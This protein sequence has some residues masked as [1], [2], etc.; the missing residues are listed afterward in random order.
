[1]NDQYF[2]NPILSHPVFLSGMKSSGKSLLYCLMMPM[3]KFEGSCKDFL[4]NHILQLNYF[5]DIPNSAASIQ[6]KSIFDFKLYN[7][8]IGRE[9]NFRVDDET[10]AWAAADPKK[11]FLKLFNPRGLNV[12]E[13]MYI[14]NRRILIDSHNVILHHDFLTKSFDQ[15]TIVNINRSPASILHSWIRDEFYSEKTL[16]NK[17]SQHL[18][19]L[20]DGKPVPL[21]LRG[22]GEK[23][24]L[25]GDNIDR[26]TQVFFKLN[27][28]EKVQRKNI[29]FKKNIIDISFE[30]IL[31]DPKNVALNLSNK[32]EDF[33][34]VNLDWIFIREGV[35]RKWSINEEY[36]K[37]EGTKEKIKF[38]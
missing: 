1:M 25:L 6:L 32:L 37:L 7:A 10:S 19:F 13:K 29:K 28:M 34:V 14:E 15:Y 26:C 33:S 35:P 12:A 38:K 2:N 20:Y 9:T 21:Y 31:V 3:E 11:E 16:E 27:E 30:K 23:E 4:I 18:C 8:S 22:N 17:L 5:G 24:F 36:E